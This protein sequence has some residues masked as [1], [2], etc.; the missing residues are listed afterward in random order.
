MTDFSPGNNATEKPPPA[1]TPPLDHKCN[2]I[3]PSVTKAKQNGDK[4]KE[5]VGRFDFQHTDAPLSSH[6]V[7]QIHLHLLHEWQQQFHETTF[8]DNYNSEIRDIKLNDWNN[9]KY[10]QSFKVHLKRGRHKTFYI[11]HRIF[12][13][14]LLAALKVCVQ[15]VLQTYNCRVTQH[16]WGEDETD[17]LKLGHIIGLNPTHYSPGL[18]Q[19]IVCNARELLQQALRCH[20]I[21]WCFRNLA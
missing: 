5:I 17:I 2:A 8:F 20:Q 13:R 12:T 16:Y 9:E 11:I 19:Q 1:P 21:N 3:E 14:H 18:A 7:A 15:P 4:M 10:K 6:S